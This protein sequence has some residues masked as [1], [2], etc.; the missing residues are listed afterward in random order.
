MTAEESL[1]TTAAAMI[2]ARKGILAI[3]E[4]VP[5][6]TKR[7]AEFGIESTEDSR[8]S[9]REMLVTTPDIGQYISA[10]ILFDETIRQKTPGGRTFVDVLKDAGIIPGIKV[11]LGA[12]PLARAPG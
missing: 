3:D 5:T 8:R 12:R 6:C 10:A 7:F 11:D 1:K 9:Y 2:A 4:T